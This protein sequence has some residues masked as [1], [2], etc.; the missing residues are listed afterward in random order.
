MDFGLLER[1]GSHNV[2]KRAESIDACP[3][4]EGLVLEN[5]FVGSKRYGVSDIQR[6]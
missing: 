5:K 1:D 2:S 4:M 3:E 6:E